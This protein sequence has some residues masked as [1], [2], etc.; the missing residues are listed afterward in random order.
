MLEK[1]LKKQGFRVKTAQDGAAGLALIENEK[2][3]VVFSDMLIPKIDGFDLCR[4]IK[5][6]E[7]FKHTKVVLMTAVY[8]GLAFNQLVEEAGAD[9]SLEKPLDMAK[10][11]ALVE[12]IM[13]S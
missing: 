7:K 5:S 10:I 6:D 13:K 8:K 9:F 12:S 2:P 4:E 11:L 3:D 1:T